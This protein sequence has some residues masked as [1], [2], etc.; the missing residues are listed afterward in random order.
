LIRATRPGG[1]AGALSAAKPG[2]AA[3]SPAARMKR[4][5]AANAD[6]LDDMAHIPFI[7]HMPPPH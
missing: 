5:E 1:V 7:P 3:S 2:I 6:V 4:V